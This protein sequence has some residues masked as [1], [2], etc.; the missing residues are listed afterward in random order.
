MPFVKGQSG[1]PLGRKK[2]SKN[3]ST[4]SLR[5]SFEMLLDDNKEQLK[6]D[7]A[8]MKP[9]ER[10]KFIIELSKFVIPT[11]KSSEVTQEITQGEF[12]PLEIFLSNSD[13]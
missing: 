2:G 12:K 3:K 8:S 4:V 11:L 10:V 13:N 9:E 6:N 1:N 7:L 5:K